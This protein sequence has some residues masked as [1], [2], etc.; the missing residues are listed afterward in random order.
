MGEC[1]ASASC[2]RRAARLMANSSAQ[3]LGTTPVP[4][5][6]MRETVVR[7]MSMRETTTRE[8]DVAMVR[9]MQI[10]NEGMRVENV[11]MREQLDRLQ[12][13]IDDAITN[14]RNMVCW[15]VG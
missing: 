4:D 12:M 13:D 2:Q 9:Q 14:G 5:G 3:E 11:A 1:G 6:R 8:Y 7:E 15:H 10:D